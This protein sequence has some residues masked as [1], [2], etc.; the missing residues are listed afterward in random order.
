MRDAGKNG[1]QEL[2]DQRTPSQ[3]KAIVATLVVASVFGVLY[4]SASGRIADKKAAIQAEGKPQQKAEESLLLDGRTLERDLYDRLQAELEQKS[5]QLDEARETFEQ[6]SRRM[7]KMLGRFKSLT[8]QASRG[9]VNPVPSRTDKTL[10]DADKR[11]DIPPPPPPPSADEIRGSAVAGNGAPVFAAPTGKNGENVEVEEVVGGI[12]HVTSDVPVEPE[13]P[14]RKKNAIHLAP[15]FMEAVLLSGMD[16]PITGSAMQN[17]KPTMLRIAAPAVLPNRVKAN[18]K[19]CFVIASGFGSL[20]EERINM[21]LVRLSCVAR[22]GD[23]VIE[24]KVKGYVV[25]SDGKVGLHARVY[26]KAGPLLVR[27]F[28]AG[29]A[30]GVAEV[31]KQNSYSTS[32]SAL[33][34]TQSIA[35]GEALNAGVAGGLSSASGGLASFY[36]KLSEQTLPTLEVGPKKKVTVVLTE[37][38][39]LHIRT[40]CEDCSDAT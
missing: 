26:M 1:V 15:S 27:Q 29:V 38:V 40:N 2:W 33:G 39:D 32:V 25:D 18:L 24:E 36:K 28:V 16:A 20:A 4:W 34:T 9:Q 19:G 23:A 30:E 21:R 37:G 35:S 11:I 3:K 10:T 17:P 7:D 13:T 8:D 31:V 22:N 5:R 14:E 6:Q 12:G